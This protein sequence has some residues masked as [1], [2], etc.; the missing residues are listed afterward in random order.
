MG[1]HNICAF[2]ELKERVVNGGKNPRADHV[3]LGAK[4]R[5]VQLPGL[6][7]GFV[8]DVF[9]SKPK[10]RGVT[11]FSEVLQLGVVDAIGRSKIDPSRQSSQVRPM[12]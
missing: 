6:S 7:I 2:L 3:E 1:F 8:E 12:Q 5:R 11:D 4:F 10:G 9:S